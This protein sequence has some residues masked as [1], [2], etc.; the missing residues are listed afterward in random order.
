[1]CG[2]GLCSCCEYPSE[3][4]ILSRDILFLI[5]GR[6]IIAVIVRIGILI[7]RRITLIYRR[8][9]VLLTVVHGWLLYI[10][11]VIL[12]RSII[13]VLLIVLLSVSGIDETE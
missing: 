6:I 12:L 13:A 9:L 10:L 1:M 2:A 5:A 11:V 4:K 3:R 7:C 8:L